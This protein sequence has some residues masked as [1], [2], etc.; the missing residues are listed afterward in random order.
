MFIEKYKYNDLLFPPHAPN[1]QYIFQCMGFM[2]KK[3]EMD[4][5]IHCKIISEF[6]A[7]EL[8]TTLGIICHDKHDWKN[9]T[10]QYEITKFSFII[11]LI[12]LSF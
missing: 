10:F 3:Q 1:G 11:P 5:C 2:R 8:F 6:E 9:I 7:E 4:S 12:S